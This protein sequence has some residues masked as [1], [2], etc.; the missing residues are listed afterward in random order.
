MLSPPLLKTDNFWQGHPLLKEFCQEQ[1]PLISGVF[2][3]ALAASYWQAGYI[4]G[5]DRIFFVA[6]IKVPLWHL[7]WM[8][9]WTGYIMGLIG[10]ASG[11]FSLPYT[12]SILQF[13][14]VAVSPTSLITTFINPFGALLGYRKGGQWN[15]DLARWLCVGA[16]LGSPLGPYIRVHWLKDPEP[17]KMVLGWGLLT[18]AA[19][20]W[21]QVTPWYLGRT[22]RQQA[23]KE[24]FD[25]TLENGDTLGGLPKDFKIVTVKKTWKTVRIEYWGE[26]QSFNVP[27]MLVI[28]FGVGV[29]A[30][31]LGVG[32]GFILVPIMVTVFE[33]PLYVL[34]AATIPFVIT[35]SVTG[36][37]SYV[38]TQMFLTGTS[39]APDWGF[40]LF[41]ACGAL[42]GAWA[43]SKTQK[44]IPEK[45]LK[46][47][48]GTVT[49]LV[50]FYYVID[51]FW[52]MP[53]KV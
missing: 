32:G 30:S 7:I 47:M 12:M 36:L 25:R 50:G 23:F 39:I 15:L 20:L 27:A 51:Y 18:M 42:L 8:G 6:G 4:P 43:A 2:L 44:L 24:K 11:I 48:L 9:F 45:Q 14:S 1:L 33:V 38:L 53:F 26:E 5:A 49:G 19:Y 28:G 17:F 13:D 10:E 29:V 35:L 31:T 40:G 34:V 22:R 21:I 3:A 46:L 37:F 16:V 52:T 41:T